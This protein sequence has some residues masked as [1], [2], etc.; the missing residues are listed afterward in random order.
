MSQWENL[1][2][3]CNVGQVDERDLSTSPR[4]NWLGSK[5]F[6][7]VALEFTPMS[8][9]EPAQAPPRVKMRA[10]LG[11]VV[12][13]KRAFGH[14]LLLALA[15]EV[16]TVASPLFMQWVVDHA[17]V[18]ADRDLLMTLVLGFS[19]L[20]LVKTSV[21]AMRGWMLIVLGTSLKVQGRANLFA[22]L[23]NL[24][25]AYFETRYLGDVMSRFGSQE[26]ILQAVSTD[27]VETVMDGL[28][29]VVMLIVMFVY[30]PGLAALVVA[31]AALYGLLR[32]ASYTPLRRASA[33]AIA[34]AARRDTH[35]LETLRG[36]KTIKLFNGQE[37]RRS[38]WSVHWLFW[39]YGLA[40]RGC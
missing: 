8:S 33:E 6:T 14:L 12:G 31:G 22:H 28:L 17:L 21:S 39:S 23:V 35:F 3:G 15:I 2:T 32:W 19:L 7:G 9:F 18:T 5:G 34:W 36:I 20:L 4:T 25:T 10:L 37:G 30:A 1:A 16:F 11:R 27:V 26:T 13:L 38:H 24:P 40:P 29:V